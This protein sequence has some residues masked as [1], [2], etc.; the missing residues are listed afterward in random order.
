MA[1]NLGFPFISP[2]PLKIV[3]VK[4]FL[5]YQ[6]CVAGLFVCLF[7]PAQSLIDMAT[8][9]IFIVEKADKNERMLRC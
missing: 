9:T 5:T 3:S 7:F 4:P 1:K 8:D 2:I 6:N